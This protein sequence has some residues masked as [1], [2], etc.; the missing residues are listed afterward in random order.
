M[1]TEVAFLTEYGWSVDKVDVPSDVAMSESQDRF[2][3]W[4][5]SDD[6]S[7]FRD[8]WETREHATVAVFVM[9][10]PRDIDDSGEG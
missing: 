8:S 4:V 7:A 10:W 9:A 6:G 2:I 5:Y 3:E 1:M